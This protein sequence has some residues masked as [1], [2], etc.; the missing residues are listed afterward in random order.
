MDN[1]YKYSAV[2][3]GQSDDDITCDRHRWPATS[4]VERYDLR[5]VQEYRRRQASTTEPISTVAAAALL[6]APNPCEELA[7]SVQYQPHRTLMEEGLIGLKSPLSVQ[8][9]L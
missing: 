9:R 2:Q 6:A 5:H 3:A 4:A 7:P 8:I 1:K